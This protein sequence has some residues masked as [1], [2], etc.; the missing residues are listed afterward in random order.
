[1]NGTGTVDEKMP[2]FYLNYENIDLFENTLPSVYKNYFFFDCQ[3]ATTLFK[4]LRYTGKITILKSKPDAM[5]LFFIWMFLPF[6]SFQ[7]T[8]PGSDVFIIGG[9]S[10]ATR[11]GCSDDAET[12]ECS[13]DI[14]L[15]PMPEQWEAYNTWMIG[16]TKLDWQ[17][18]QAEQVEGLMF[19]F[20]KKNQM[21]SFNLKEIAKKK[22]MLLT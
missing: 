3:R 21:A 8:F 7:E 1:M 20:E 19:F 4:R 14:V 18:P 10:P 22:I 5:L 11:P 6:F 2:S 16:D 13:V 9:V 15:N 12:S 17:G